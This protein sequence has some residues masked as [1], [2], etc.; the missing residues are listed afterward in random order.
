M[1]EGD[2]Q[3]GSMLAEDVKGGQGMKG[4]GSHSPPNGKVGTVIGIIANGFTGLQHSG[5]N[6]HAA[7]SMHN[8]YAPQGCASSFSPLCAS[9]PCRIS[10]EVH[11]HLEAVHKKNTKHNN[12][13]HSPLRCLGGHH[14]HRVVQHADECVQS[15]I[16]LLS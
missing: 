3:P 1:I 8:G 10:T 13:P 14:L 6:G 9:T 7:N 4:H 2:A 15:I 11:A 5:A 16:C 12:K